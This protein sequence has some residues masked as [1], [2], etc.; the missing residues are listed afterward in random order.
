MVAWP[1]APRGIDVRVV[2]WTYAQG[3]R[4][5]YAAWS[6]EEDWPAGRH[7]HASI[8]VAKFVFPMYICPPRGLFS[9]LKFPSKREPFFHTSVAC[10][11]EEQGRNSSTQKK[12]A[13]Q[14]D[15]C[16]R[17]NYKTKCT[18]SVCF[19]I[20]ETIDGRTKVYEKK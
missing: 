14:G 11:K 7:P 10:E 5:P 16:R 1:Y 12:E 17:D 13:K 4:T 3:V 19:F 2:A 15:A 6:Y 9:T 18:T 8:P 20:L